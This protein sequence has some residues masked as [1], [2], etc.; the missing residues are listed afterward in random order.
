LALTDINPSSPL[1][2]PLARRGELSDTAEQ[3]YYGL[4]LET[5]VKIAILTPLFIAVY[6]I[7]LR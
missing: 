2:S 3:E 4:S 7:V 5:W 6:W 1:L